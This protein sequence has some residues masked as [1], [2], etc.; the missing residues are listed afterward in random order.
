[1]AA[2][3]PHLASGPVSFHADFNAFSA[4]PIFTSDALPTNTTITAASFDQ[5]SV[6]LLPVASGVI[7]GSP[8]TLTLTALPA[9]RGDFN[10][11]GQVSSADLPVMLQALTGLNTFQADNKLSAEDLLAIGDTNGDGNI[12]N[13]DLQALLNALKSGGGSINTL[14]EPSSLVL[15][16][17]GL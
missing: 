10:L 3:F 6:T 15:A 16:T 11:D 5:S 9:L 4:A 8:T 1:A 13:A 7:T 17:M 12:S 2:L 14:P